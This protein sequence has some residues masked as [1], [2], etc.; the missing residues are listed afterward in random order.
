MPSTPTITHPPQSA[1]PPHSARTTTTDSESSGYN[2]T[3]PGSVPYPLV[4]ESVVVTRPRQS[5]LPPHSA[6]TTHTPAGKAQGAICRSV[7]AI[8]AASTLCSCGVRAAARRWCSASICSTSATMRA[9]RATIK[10]ATG[11]WLTSNHV[12]YWSHGVRLGSQ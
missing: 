9:W 12:I 7:A 2:S 3:T 4:S 8:C 11:A 10:S 1:P 5:A 6:R